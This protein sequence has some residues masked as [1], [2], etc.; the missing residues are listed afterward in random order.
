[1]LLLFLLLFLVLGI[2]DEMTPA[3]AAPLLLRGHA[4]FQ[5]AVSIKQRH[6]PWPVAIVAAA[7]TVSLRAAEATGVAPP[8]AVT[9]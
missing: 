8:A 2:L 5:P 4:R 9:D 7:P 3:A 6:A 1:M